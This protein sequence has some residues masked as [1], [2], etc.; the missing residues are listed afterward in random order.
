MEENSKSLITV[1]SSLA[2]IEKQIAIGEKILSLRL[3]NQDHKKIKDLLIFLATKDNF[4]INLLSHFYSFNIETIDNNRDILDWIYLSSNHNIVWTTLLLEK[5]KEKWCWDE[6]LERHKIGEYN[7]KF[8]TYLCTKSISTNESIQWEINDI[9]KFKNYIYWFGF[10][11]IVKL[12]WTIKII[13]R[14]NFNFFT[15]S[16]NKSFQCPEH[17]MNNLDNLSRSNILWDNFSFGNLS[18]NPAVDWNIERIK[19]NINKIKFP[20][21]FTN[22]GIDWTESLF[23]ELLELYENYLPEEDK[24]NRIEITWKYFSTNKSFLWSAEFIKKSESKLSW[25]YDWVN[26]ALSLSNNEGLDWNENFIEKYVEKWNWFY[27]SKNSKLPWS[28]NFINRYIHNWEWDNLSGNQGLPWS[29]NLISE[30]IEKW[31]WKKL[32][33]NP[34]LPWSLD[35]FEKYSNKWDFNILLF[36]KGFYKIFES[37]LT[38]DL[39][40][41]IFFEIKKDKAYKCNISKS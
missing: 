39:I 13:E 22:E 33:Q 24:K 41:E 15:L 26:P 14:F 18:K 2:K 25:G 37:V 31:N 16:Q 9:E 5:Y 23:K 10:S 32:S 19:K 28:E 35:F 29:E 38:D 7:S 11:R 36:N 3:S 30:H 4:S 20:E 27:L 12:E 8:D 17:I 34:N 21:L 40:E 6:S 1:N